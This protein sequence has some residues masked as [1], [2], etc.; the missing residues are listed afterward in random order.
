MGWSDSPLRLVS[1]LVATPDVAI[2]KWIGPLGPEVAFFVYSPILD[3]WIFNG[4]TTLPF[5]G[6]HFPYGYDVDPDH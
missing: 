4:T 5:P 6:A 3:E 1:R 2:G